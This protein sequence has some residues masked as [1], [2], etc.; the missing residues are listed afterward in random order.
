MSKKVVLILVEGETEETLIAEFLEERFGDLE[1]MVDVKHGDVLSDWNSKFS[2]N[3]TKFI[4][5]E[6]VREYLQEM[7]F[8]ASDLL[9]VFQLTD[10]DGCFIPSD[11]VV[12][13]EQYGKDNY[14]CDDSI[15][16]GSSSK[17]TLIEERN[18]K[19]SQRIDI[20]NTYHQL[21]LKKSKII[22]KIFYFSTNLE[23]VLWDE[24]NEDKANK[25]HKLDTF[26][27]TPGQTIEALLAQYFTVS[28]GESTVDVYTNSWNHI[29]EGVNSLARQTNIPLLVN[30]LE[31][32]SLA[33]VSGSA[34]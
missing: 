29:K 33:R 8:L 1:I 5:S 28:D 14:Y 23:H 30:F 26:I 4:V 6:W 34:T 3:Q 15:C 20:L 19:K 31:E 17:K 12:V 11:Q 21:H 10:T 9:A 2:V 24:R 13:D 18:D 27:D 32:E 7:K 25:L 22:Y 16:V